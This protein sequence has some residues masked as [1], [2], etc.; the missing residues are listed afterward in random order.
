M[1]IPA[2]TPNNWQPGVG[3]T[4]VTAARLNSPETALAALLDYFRTTL[5]LAPTRPVSPTLGTVWMQTA[6]DPDSTPP[7][8]PVLAVPTATAT[9]VT[10]TWSGSTDNVSV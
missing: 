4:E 10:L 1:P 6:G 5:V 9:A 3:G 7:T 2:F 8:A